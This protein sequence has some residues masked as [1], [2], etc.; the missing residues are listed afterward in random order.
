MKKHFSDITGNEIPKNKK[1][2]LDFNIEDAGNDKY[3]YASIDCSIDEL[4]EVARK[5]LAIAMDLEKVRQDK[6]DAKINPLPAA[7]SS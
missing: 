1:V 3:Y 5:K 6:R 4:P 2:S 7:P